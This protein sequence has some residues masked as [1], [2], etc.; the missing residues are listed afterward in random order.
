MRFTKKYVMSVTLQHTKNRVQN[1]IQKTITRM[2]AEPEIGPEAVDTLFELSR[3][4]DH[5]GEF[6]FAGDDDHE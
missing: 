5:I 1:S 3:L 6:R 2:N 4:M